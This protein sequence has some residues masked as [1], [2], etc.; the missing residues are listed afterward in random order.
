MSVRKRDG[1]T[2]PHLYLLREKKFTEIS[3][4]SCLS[5]GS[6]IFFCYQN[7]VQ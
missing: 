5:L 6:D 3:D 1:G 4:I 2:A 7:F